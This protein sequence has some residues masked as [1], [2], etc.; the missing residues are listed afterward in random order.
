MKNRHVS[1]NSAKY[2]WDTFT[3]WV[4][5]A[6]SQNNHNHVSRNFN[7]ME[8][9]LPWWVEEGRNC[10][11]NVIFNHMV[12]IRCRNIRARNFSIQVQIVYSFVCPYMNCYR[13]LHRMLIIYV[14]NSGDLY[15]STIYFDFD[16]S[17][18]S[19]G[20]QSLL[21]PNPRY[22]YTF[23]SIWQLEDRVTKERSL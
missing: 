1:T 17:G 11:F 20:I 12:V 7:G 21:S 4:H 2:R 14:K 13:Q 23:V 3:K 16:T 6:V 18:S 15:L 8:F 9:I 19:L 5:L 10:F 22:G